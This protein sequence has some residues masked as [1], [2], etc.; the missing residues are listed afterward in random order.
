MADLKALF[1]ARDEKFLE[2][3]LKI[4]KLINS[5][6]GCVTAYLSDIDEAVQQGIITWEDASIVD[7]MVVVIGMVDYDLG[8][9]INLY[10]KEYTITE[11]NF[12]DF[13]RVVHMSVPIDLAE[14]G[15]EEKILNYL[16]S[17]GEGKDISEF[18]NAVSGIPEPN[19]EEEFDLSELTEDQ[20]ESLKLHN[21]KGRGGN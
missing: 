18:S 2:E 17:Q 5:T 8:D 3:T 9:V 7:D 20:I 14:E 13:Q 15:N 19:T 16:Y 12:D 1:K 6:L 11:E 4:F 21:L 10:G